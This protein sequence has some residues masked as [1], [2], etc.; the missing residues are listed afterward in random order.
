[1]RLVDFY[2]FEGRDT[3]LFGYFSSETCHLSS[4]ENGRVISEKKICY[5]VG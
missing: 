4:C 1:M 5:L 3:F 2:S